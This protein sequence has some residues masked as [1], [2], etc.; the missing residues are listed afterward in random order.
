MKKLFIT[1]VLALMAFTSVSAQDFL[2]GVKGG[3]SGNWIPKTNINPDDKVLP[4][5]GFYG[6]LTGT[7]DLSSQS[8]LQ[9]E[10]LYARK[11]I[12]T[13]GETFGNT[14]WRKLHYVQVPLLLGFKLMDDNFRFMVGPEFG[15]CLGSKVYDSAVTVSPAS[16]SGYKKFNFAVA[17]QTSYIFWEGLGVDFKVDYAFSKTFEANDAGRNLCLQIGLCYI[18]GY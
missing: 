18:F 9:A 2:V 11:G 10:V 8:F 7:L 4:N 13:R 17:L 14:Y 5:A 6:G 3:F 16:A 1:L 15:Y 12:S